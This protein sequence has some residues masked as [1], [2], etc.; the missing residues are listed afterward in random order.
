MAW[1]LGPEAITLLESIDVSTLGVNGDEVGALGL[2]LQRAGQRS[3]LLGRSNVARQ[4]AAAG[5]II[6]EQDH[7]ARFDLGQQRYRFRIQLEAAKGRSA[8][9]ARRHLRATASGHRPLCPQ[10]AT[11]AT[12]NIIAKAAMRQRPKP[13]PARLRRELTRGRQQR[14]GRFILGLRPPAAVVAT[15]DAALPFASSALPIHHHSPRVSCIKP[16]GRVGDRCAHG[17]AVVPGKGFEPPRPHRATDFESAASAISPPRQQERPQ[18]GT[19]AGPGLEPDGSPH[20][21]SPK[22]NYSHRPSPGSKPSGVPSPR[23]SC[24]HP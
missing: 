5:A 6:V 8:A 2:L 11:N 14:F 22:N 21:A 16:E 23:R 9:S 20:L 15:G 3:Q 18:R 12:N 17:F 13:R 24:K 1:Q 7:A 10:A 4:L 19:A